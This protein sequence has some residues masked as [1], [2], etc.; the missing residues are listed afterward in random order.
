[1]MMFRKIDLLSTHLDGPG[2][3]VV[4]PKGARWPQYSLVTG[5]VPLQWPC[6]SYTDYRVFGV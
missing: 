5:F 1:M 6:V 3:Y 2:L 4:R